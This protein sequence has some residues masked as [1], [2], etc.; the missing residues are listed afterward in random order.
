MKTRCHKKENIFTIGL[1]RLKISEE[2][3][4]GT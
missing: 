4:R 2:G 3:K 1:D